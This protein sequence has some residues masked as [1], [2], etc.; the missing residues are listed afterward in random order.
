MAEGECD[1]NDI[2]CQEK[3]RLHLQGLQGLVGS[4]VFKNQFPEL[5]EL[6]G[7]LSEM[8]AEQ[9]G[10]LGE[11]YGRCNA[12]ASVLPAQVIGESDE[13]TES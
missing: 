1:V 9:E 11:A 13:H 3:V 5:T 2:I 6:E 12:S 10:K 8:I 4:E 7:K